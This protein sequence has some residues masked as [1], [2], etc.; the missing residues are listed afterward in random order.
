MLTCGTGRSAGHCD[1]PKHASA[2]WDSGQ[3]LIVAVALERE[4]ERV[5]VEL[6]T[7]GRIGRDHRQS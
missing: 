2:A 4:S 5:D 3:M 1:V 6:A 7:G